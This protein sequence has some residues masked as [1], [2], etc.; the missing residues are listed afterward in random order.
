MGF[1]AD[2]VR[3]WPI[4]PDWSD[5]MVESLSWGT[6]LMRA[7][8]TAVSQHL[9][10]QIAPDRALS[11]D[12][13]ADKDNRRFID[14]ILGGWGRNWLLPIWPDVQFLTADLASGVTEIPCLTAGY[15]FVAGG[16]ALLYVSKNNW[17][18]VEIDTV[19]TDHLALTTGT[20]A[21]Y[22]AGSRL[23][24]LR[25]A[26]LGEGSEQTF[27][28]DD[29]GKRRL[30]FNVI[31][32]CDW[33]VLSAP[34]TY[35]THPVLDVRPDESSDPSM[36][37]YR[38]TQGVLYDGAQPLTHDLPDQALIAQKMNWL[39]AGRLQHTWLRSLLY[40]LK[41]QLN[42][43]WV[44]SFA[45][46]LQSIAT[47]V[48]GS[49]SMSV[50]WAGYT[51]FAKGRDNRRDLRIEL[52]DGSVLYRRVTNAVEAGEAETLTLSSSLSGS[53]IAP[54]K[55]KQ[56]SIM[57]L[58]VMASDAVEIQHAT[59]ANGLASVTLGWQGVVPDV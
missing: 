8:G 19:E 16:K 31:E 51:Q 35:L 28:S 39:L 17:E 26:R 36:D 7:T 22:V 24:P 59:D 14:M 18:V 25:L 41:G 48:G 55:I 50:A 47:V 34:T 5:G 38:M 40:T 58:A 44:P 57:S 11:F 21:A 37:F 20:D 23:Y 4:T 43:I 54:E 32:D 53:S 56:I 15:D 29:L 27:L 1:E 30:K 2:G 13:L 9:G 49:T 10:Y 46:D 52:F 45:R 33:P 12:V 42:P 3:I 6:N